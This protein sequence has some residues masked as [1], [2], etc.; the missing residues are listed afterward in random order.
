MNKILTFFNNLF[1]Q[2]N[3]LIGILGA[4]VIILILLH[5]DS[6]N[7]AKADAQRVRQDSAAMQNKL[8][9]EKN[10]AGQF[11]TSIVAYEGKVSDLDK[12]SKDLEV[13][14]KDLKNRKPS[15]MIQTKIVYVHDT[16]DLTDSIID[17]RD[18]RYMLKWDYTNKDSSEI[19]QGN[20]TF[21]AIPVFN[22]KDYTYVLNV[23]HAKT[24]I[25]KDQL[26]L[27]FVVGVAKN[28]KTGLD[29]IFITPQN[30]NV[31]I[32][33]LKGAILNKPKEKMYSVSFN[34]GYGMVYTRGTIGF[35]PYFGIGI[36]R[37]IFRF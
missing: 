11:Q 13:K 17:K 2:K 6:C 16:I 4:A 29:E 21:I 18:G 3:L 24:Q 34:L 37:N 27:D 9:V 32:G 15:V 1:G 25:T 36:S 26:K 31:T 14:V 35:G 30:K 12:Y 28:T 10:K 20:S 22:E 7:G 5:I 19:L 33:S 23:T 8:V